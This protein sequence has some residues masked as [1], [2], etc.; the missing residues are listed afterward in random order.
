MRGSI[1]A[2]LGFLIVFGAVGGMENP[3]TSLLLLVPIA[4]AGLI[5]MASG[6]QALKENE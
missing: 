4:L 6:V 2:I 3:Q 5:I 1:R